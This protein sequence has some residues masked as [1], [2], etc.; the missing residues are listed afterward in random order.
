MTVYNSLDEMVKLKVP[1]IQRLFIQT[2]QEIVD[3]SILDEMIAAIEAG[4]AERLFKATGFTAAAIGPIIDAIEQVYKDSAQTTVS[5][6]P[7]PIITPTGPVM[8]RFDMRNKNAENDIKTNSSTLISQLTDEA[9]NNVRNTLQAGMIAGDSPR[10]TALNIIGRIDPTT[11]KRVGGVIGLT[12]N[13]EGWV[14]SVQQYLTDLNPKYFTLELRDKRFDSI[15]RKA[16]ASGEALS[17]DDISRLVT[18]YKASALQYRG[19]NIARTETIQ[20]LNRGEYRANMQLVEEGLIKA[21]AITKEWDDVGDRKVR[22][23]HRYLA[24]TYGKGN[25]IGLDEPFVSSSG[26]SLMF[27]G[28]TSLGAGAD[29]VSHCRCRQKIGVDWLSG[30]D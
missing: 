24:E 28:D 5:E 26:A 1:E 6:M 17:A 18:R 3:T 23:T 15:V 25:G 10:T 2:M 14:R 8:F 11:K 4:D 20:S 30:V 9:R 12:S 19:E 7:S 27:P 16:I 29:E 13:Q 22:A 21:S